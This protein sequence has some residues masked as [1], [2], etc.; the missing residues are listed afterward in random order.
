MHVSIIMHWRQERFHRR[1]HPN[2]TRFRSF[3]SLDGHFVYQL[4]CSLLQSIEVCC[5]KTI[6]RLVNS[7]FCTFADTDKLV[8]FHRKSY[9]SSSTTSRQHTQVTRRTTHVGISRQSEEKKDGPGFLLPILKEEKSTCVIKLVFSVRLR[10]IG[11]R[12]SLKLII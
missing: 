11:N 5:N 9:R 8:F 12:Q 3:I 10:T 1:P 6:P 4:H 2:T 7:T